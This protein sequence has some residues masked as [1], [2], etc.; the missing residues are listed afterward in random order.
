[1]SLQSQ[2]DTNDKSDGFRV[3]LKQYLEKLVATHAREAADPYLVKQVYDTRD[4]HDEELK[5]LWRQTSFETRQ[6]LA[7]VF[8]KELENNWSRNYRELGS[9]LDNL[10]ESMITGIEMAYAAGYMFGKGWISQEQ[11]T[12]FILDLGDKLAR[13]VRSELPKA[14]SKGIGFASAFTA[15]SVTDQFTT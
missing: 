15:V 10:Q 5:E 11:H 3:M 8:Q 7:S 14:K 9:V 12:E 6:K 1:M 4:Q 13:E 2:P